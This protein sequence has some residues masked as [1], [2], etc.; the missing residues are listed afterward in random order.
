MATAALARRFSS[1]VSISTNW[2]RRAT[3]ALRAWVAA[4]ARGRTA[5]RTASAKWA[6]TWASMASVLANLPVAL[7]KS[8]TWRGLTATTGSPAL[9]RTPRTGNSNPPVAS[10]TINVG[11][12]ARSWT[13]SSA[14]PAVWLSTCHCSPAGRTATSRL[15]RATSMPMKISAAISPPDSQIACTRP[16][17]RDAGSQ[18]GPGN[19]SGSRQGRLG[20][21][22]FPAVSSG[23]KER[24]S[25]PVLSVTSSAHPGDVTKIQ[26]VRS[27]ARAQQRLAAGGAAPPTRINVIPSTFGSLTRA[28]L[29]Y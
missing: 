20:R 27:E 10:S 25:V 15:A 7:A 28:R 3:S 19:C 8:R 9:P 2:R 1:A 17:L 24:R 26:G 6:S 29:L 16:T 12:K 23:P 11:R 5:G 13:S 4:S 14:M 22:S 18:C 21:P